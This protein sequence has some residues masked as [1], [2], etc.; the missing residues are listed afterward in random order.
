MLYRSIKNQ[1][2]CHRERKSKEP[3][4]TKEGT[5]PAGRPCGSGGEKEVL[6]PTPT[7]ARAIIISDGAK[8]TDIICV[9]F[10]TDFFKT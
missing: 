7:V 10:F 4:V 9:I 5:R 8:G 1:N 2:K 6:L 3:R